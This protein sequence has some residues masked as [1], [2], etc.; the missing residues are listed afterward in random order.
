MDSP[1][2]ERATDTTPANQYGKLTPQT[3][4]CLGALFNPVVRYYRYIGIGKQVAAYPIF[5]SN[6]LHIL[7]G[8][9]E[10]Y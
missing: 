1:Q 9:I 2:R 4:R 10:V 8:L 3:I 6:I 7:K 5:F